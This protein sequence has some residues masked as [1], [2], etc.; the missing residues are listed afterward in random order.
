VYD[1]RYAGKELLFEPSGGL[2]N[3]A[4]VMR[5]RPTDSWWSIITGDAIGGELDGE[6]L[7]EIAAGEKTRWGE[8]ERRYP[9]TRVWSVDGKQHIESNPY[10]NYF[11]SSRTFRETETPD[12]RLRDKESVYAFQ[13]D[14]VTYAVPH[15][16]IF[17]GAVF[18]LQN[19][20]EIFLYREPGSAIYAST[21]AYVSDS[22]GKKSRFIRG[23]DGWMDS[24]LQVKFS[25]KRGFATDPEAHDDEGEAPS[26]L[27]GFDTFWYIWSA[28]HEGVMLLTK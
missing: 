3:A 22:D 12:N 7:K 24:Q 11:V 25:N 10:D 9:A 13:M 26:R 27:G 19:D 4:L 21:F 8:W 18:E 14:G 20:K 17:G 15:S 23:D 6:P 2:L 16:V 28:T 5:D 1:R